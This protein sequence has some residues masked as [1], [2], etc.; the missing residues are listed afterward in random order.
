MF[1]HYIPQNFNNNSQI[2]KSKTKSMKYLA[3]IR[4]PLPFSWSLKL[5]WWRKMN[6]FESD[7]VSLRE[8]WKDK[9]MNSWKCSR[10]NPNILKN[11]P[12][13]AKH[14][15]FAPGLCRE[16]VARTLKTK[17]LKNFLSVFCN[18]KFYPRGSREV[19]RENFCVPPQ[20]DHLPVNKSPD[21]AARN[22]KNLNFEKYS[23]YFSRLGHWPASES[24]KIS[25]WARD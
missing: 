10:E 13:S 2:K 22:I 4:K 24:R 25:V 17:I 3:K 5:K 16:Q 7:M 21:W 6:V 19:S 15:I 11:W 18:W 20:L 8:S 23:K 9:T 14:A 12:N 1:E